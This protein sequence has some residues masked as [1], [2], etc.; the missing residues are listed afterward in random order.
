MLK[1]SSS[2]GA[3]FLPFLLAG[4]KSLAAPAVSPVTAFQTA[5]FW[6]P[7]GAAYPPGS[8]EQPE[9]W[10]ALTLNQPCSPL[11]GWV[12]QWAQVFFQD[13]SRGRFSVPVPVQSE[14]D[15]VYR[16]Q[17]PRRTSHHLHLC[18]WVMLS[19]P[20]VLCF[21][22]TRL[23]PLLACMLVCSGSFRP[24]GQR[25]KGGSSLKSQPVS[26]FPCCVLGGSH[27]Q[28]WVKQLCIIV[29]KRGIPQLSRKRAY[30]AL[31]SQPAAK[32]LG[33]RAKRRRQACQQL[34][35]GVCHSRGRSIITLCDV[36]KCWR[37]QLSESWRFEEKHW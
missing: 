9:P 19:L 34:A 6:F 4:I 27:F 14:S 25:L 2:S 18:P 5:A 20:N 32:R 3:K 17:R 26:H 15:H 11:N 35:A 36:T 24:V 30:L 13:Y 21:Y 1:C 29:I 22:V 31:C 28:L 8:A 7:G 12:S 37:P 16:A 10:V 23:G 33:W